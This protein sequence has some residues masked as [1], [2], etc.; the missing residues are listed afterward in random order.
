MVCSNEALGVSRAFLFS[1]VPLS[2][3]LGI[4]WDCYIHAFSGISPPAQRNHKYGS[5]AYN[6]VFVGIVWSGTYFKVI[7]WRPTRGCPR[8]RGVLKLHLF[9]LNKNKIH[10]AS[11]VQ[12]TGAVKEAGCQILALCSQID[13]GGR[14][15]A[16]LHCKRAFE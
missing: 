14:K 4:P 7:Y 15:E 9:G 6:V 10:R 12:L 1:N 16:A 5:E 2:F 8:V 11:C 3:C 13:F